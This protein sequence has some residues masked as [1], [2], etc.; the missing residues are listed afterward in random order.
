MSAWAQR[1]RDQPAERERALLDMRAAVAANDR[2]R[3]PG[4]D[5][6]VEAVDRALEQMI[7]A[8]VH[9][10]ACDSVHAT[11]TSISRRAAAQQQHQQ[12][13]AVT[14]PPPP[15]ASMSADHTPGDLPASDSSPAAPPSPAAASTPCVPGDLAG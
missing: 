11:R 1:R 12:P 5:A 4:A 13:A 14:P 8:G 10:G 15:A 6:V 3:I 9:R 7:T 2:D